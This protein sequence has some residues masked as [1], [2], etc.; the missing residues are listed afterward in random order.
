MAKMRSAIPSYFSQIQQPQLC[1]AQSQSKEGQIHRTST[2]TPTV[3]RRLRLQQHECI[4]HAQ[5]AAAW[6][7]AL[8]LQVGQPLK[9][10]RTWETLAL[11]KVRDKILSLGSELPFSKSLEHTILLYIA[12]TAQISKCDHGTKS[13]L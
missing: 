4:T 10:H 8:V 1:G 2:H 9:A 12:Y 5:N 3:H 7:A 13:I 6:S 11:P